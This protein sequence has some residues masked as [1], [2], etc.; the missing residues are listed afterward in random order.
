MPCQT[1]TIAETKP[2]LAISDIVVEPSPAGDI[3]ENN[4]YGVYLEVHVDGS[5]IGTLKL[6]WGDAITGYHE[7]KT[8]IKAGNHAYV[9]T[10]PHGTHEV[11]A[12]LF[13]VKY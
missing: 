12:T 6:E 4:E 7:T 3:P 5:G 1:I 13:G 10:L 11:C 8:G 9:Q 2:T